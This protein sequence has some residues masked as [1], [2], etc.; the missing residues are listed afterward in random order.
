MKG[1]GHVAE[2]AG[3]EKQ[4]LEAAVIL[5][6]KRQWYIKTVVAA[7]NLWCACTFWGNNKNQENKIV[8]A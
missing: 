6:F 3:M 8:T 2:I 4:E 7:P 1:A 5:R